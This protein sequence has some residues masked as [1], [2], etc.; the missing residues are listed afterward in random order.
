MKV[1]KKRGKILQ[2]IGNRK[3]VS[4]YNIVPGFKVIG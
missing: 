4:D 2:S 1:K 3:K